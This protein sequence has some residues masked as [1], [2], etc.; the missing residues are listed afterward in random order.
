MARSNVLQTQT[1]DFSTRTFGILIAVVACL[2]ILFGLW[3]ISDPFIDG[4]YHYNWGPP[5]WLI[6]AE[7][8]NEVGLSHTYFGLKDYASHPQLIGP[9]VAGWTRVAGYSEA[10]IRMLSLL[11]TVLA[12]AFLSLAMRSFFGNRRAVAFAL[13]FASLPMVYIY[14]KK[15]DQEALLIVFLG[16]HLWGIGTLERSKKIGLAL[17]AFGS[18]GMMLSDWS[19]AVFALATG[20]GAFVA[21]GWK[22]HKRRILEFVFVSWSASALGLVLFL[23]QSYL[24]TGASNV[25]EFVRNYAELWKYRAGQTVD[26]PSWMTWVGKQMTN[27]SLNFTMPLALTALFGLMWQLRKRCEGD[28][29]AW[30]GTVFVAA[31]FCANIAYMVAVPQ[32]SAVHLYYQYYLSVPLALGLVLLLDFVSARVRARHARAL[33]YWSLGLLL[34]IAASAS[35]YQYH[36]L[37]VDDMWGDVSDIELIR[38][39]RNLSAE[40]S[41]ITVNTEVAALDWF[42]NPNIPYYAGREI[43]GSLLASTTPTT[44]WILIPYGILDDVVRVYLKVPGYG[45]SASIHNLCVTHLCLVKIDPAR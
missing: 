19:G 2:Q 4:R 8:I 21:W 1:K 10:S 30:A 36:K 28:R 25:Q 9:I 34:C 33:W 32:A 13:L 26:R 44:G 29:A 35:I 42:S 23:V 27:I 5:F 39:I 40:Q 12:T 6:Q 17:V 24:Q 3:H 16:L 31:I 38:S 14:G 37:L 20:I 18:L 45:P 15:L 22:E 11:L 7:T 41:V 43:P